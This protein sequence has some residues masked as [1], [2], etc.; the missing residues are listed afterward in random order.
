[1]TP[2]RPS[3]PD[4]SMLWVAVGLGVFG[5]SNFVFLALAGRDLGPATSAAVSVAWTLLNALGI[6]LFQPLEQETGRRLSAARATGGAGTNLRLMMRYALLT[7]GAIVLVGVLG[8]PWIADALFGSA[9]PVVLV[10]VL[11]LAGQ[12]LAYYARGVLAGEDRFDRYGAQLALDGT[13][14]ILVAGALY[15]TGAGSQLTYGLVLVLAPVVATLCTVRPGTLLSVARRAD[16]S[17]PVHGMASLVAASSTGQILANLGPL[18]M[19]LMATASQQ[20][21]SGR[22]VAAVTVARI[23]LFLFAAIQAVFL[24]ALAALVARGDVVGFRSSVRKAMLAS[25]ALGIVGVVGIA[26]LGHWVLWLIYGPDFTIDTTS[27]VLIA[28]SGGL[29]MLAQVFA[30]A[31]LAHHAERAVAVCWASGIVGST[32]ALLAPFTL[33]VTVSLALCAGSAVALAA[34]GLAYRG[35]VAAWRRS[36]TISEHTS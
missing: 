33:S 14:R 32:L 2:D 7:V 8:A 18:A 27:L 24:P 9:R 31:L 17:P 19:A 13:L 36:S 26:L 35:Q 6:G 25:A 10:V 15:L 29:F 34:L 30:Q 4:R 5:L 1:M 20:G 23:P 3:K 22:F 28:V 21:L 12:A 16:G 11:G